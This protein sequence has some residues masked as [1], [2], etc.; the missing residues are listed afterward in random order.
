MFLLFFLASSCWAACYNQDIFIAEKVDIKSYEKETICNGIEASVWIH[1]GNITC[2]SEG[3]R[4][5]TLFKNLRIIFG[6]LKITG[7]VDCENLNFFQDLQILNKLDPAERPFVVEDPEH[8]LEDV[9]SIQFIFTPTFD[10]SRLKGWGEVSEKVLNDIQNVTAQYRLGFCEKNEKPKKE[11]LEHFIQAVIHGVLIGLLLSLLWISFITRCFKRFGTRFVDKW[12]RGALKRHMDEQPEFQQM[13]LSLTAERTGDAPKRHSKLQS[14][15]ALAPSAEPVKEPSKRA[16]PSAEKDSLTSFSQLLPV[17]MFVRS[18]SALVQKLSE[19]LIF[20]ELQ[21][22]LEA[23]QRK[24]ELEQE[25]LERIWRVYSSCHEVLPEYRRLL[26]QFV[27]LVVVNADVPVTLEVTKYLKNMAESVKEKLELSNFLL[28]HEMRELSELF[29]KFGSN[30]I[31]HAQKT[32]H[33]LRLETLQFSKDLEDF[34]ER[35][36]AGKIDV[37]SMDLLK[38]SAADVHSAASRTP[39]LEKLFKMVRF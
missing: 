20:A 37:A 39:S 38:K 31:L 1:F 21:Q 10:C 28:E 16:F 6:Q 19:E 3:N 18:R 8:L 17:V 25:W 9:S 11:F 26:F 30:F 4:L 12:Q 35:C 29:K 24:R 7:N 27:Q 5:K 2:A 14:V 36:M 13:G 15:E 23:A 33:L 32:C 34:L 22:H